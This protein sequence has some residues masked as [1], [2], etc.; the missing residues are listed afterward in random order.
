MHIRSYLG[1]A[2]ENLFGNPDE[3][4]VEVVTGLTIIISGFV[5]Q[6]TEW[7]QDPST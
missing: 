7:L 1:G 5:F 2:L 6:N 4:D 3:Y